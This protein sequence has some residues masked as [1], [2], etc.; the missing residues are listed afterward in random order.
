MPI[1]N[2]QKTFKNLQQDNNA[3]KVNKLDDDVFLV[4]VE[5]IYVAIENMS[6]GQ[7]VVRASTPKGPKITEEDVARW[8][9]TADKTQQ[10]SDK[11]DDVLREV[12]EID[13]LRGYV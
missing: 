10:L 4:K 5:E 11:M 3:L 8:N 1:R 7:P 6:K 9:A 2:T 13:K 12:E